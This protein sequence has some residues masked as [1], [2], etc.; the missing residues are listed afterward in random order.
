MR[1][2]AA[3][4]RPLAIRGGLCDPFWIGINRMPPR[5]R[6]EPSANPWESA[7]IALG[8]RIAQ[9]SPIRGP[10]WA[11]LREPMMLPGLSWRRYTPIA[12]SICPPVGC[13]ILNSPIRRRWPFS[14]RTFAD[15]DEMQQE[16]FWREEGR[17]PLVGIACRGLCDGS[18]AP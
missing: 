7:D 2:R 11:R 8:L 1:S 10:A 15:L 16:G 3:S 9:H 5:R 17:P 14:A 12:Y 6:I 18:A 4:V 13:R